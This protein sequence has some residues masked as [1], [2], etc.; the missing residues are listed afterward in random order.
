MESLIYS[1]NATLPVFIIMGIGYF[2]RQINILSEGFVTS[3]DKFNFKV[4][5]PVMLF[6]DLACTDIKT[7]FNP[8]YALFCAAITT[9]MFVLTWIGAKLFLKD[10][11]SIGA[12]VQACYRSSVAILGI[13]FITNIYDS[14]GMAPVMII[15]TV[16]LYNIF[17]VLVLT[18]ESPSPEGKSSMSAHIKQSV[19]NIVKNPIIIGIA[20]GAAAAALGV[21]L[22]HIINKTLT[23]IGSLAS[24]LTLITIGAGFEGARAI[25]KLKLSVIASIVKLVAIPAVFLFVSIK[26]G[27]RNQELV[28]LIIMLASPTTP[29]S[30]IM[31]KNMNSDYILTSSVIVMTTLLSSLTLTFWL[32]ICKYMGLIV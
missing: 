8:K 15:G 26:A 16:P 11:Y 21:N 9:A 17:A 5:L 1:L 32:F 24:P 3:A 10:K 2:L 6:I 30:Y 23:S 22:P 7:E 20:L 18:F 12:F 31:A 27:W 19:I 29:S 14:P 25:K 4:A 28:A 13:A